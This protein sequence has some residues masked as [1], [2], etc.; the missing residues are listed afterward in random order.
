MESD[1]V[2]IGEVIKKR[3]LIWPFIPMALASLFALHNGACF[4]KVWFK[5]PSVEH[6]VTCIA[7]V[8]TLQMCVYKGKLSKG[9]KTE[10]SYNPAK[11][12]KCKIFETWA[13]KKKAEK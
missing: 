10:V 8:S 9:D 1:N 4:Y 11:P 12:K 6:P 5:I 7:E 2:F 13:P 3:V